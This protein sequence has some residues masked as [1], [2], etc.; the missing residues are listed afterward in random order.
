MIKFIFTKLIP[1]ALAIIMG[2]NMIAEELRF[3]INIGSDKNYFIQSA[4]GAFHVL[5]SESPKSR[6]IIA[7][8][9]GN[10][11]C[12]LLF[13]GTNAP[14]LIGEP[15]INKNESLT[16]N[17][18]SPA[19]HTISKTIL[20]SLR[21]TRNYTEGSGLKPIFK[22]IR[23]NINKLG[24]DTKAYNNAEKWLNP[25]W[26]ISENGKKAELYIT[27]LDCKNWYK[28]LIEAKTGNFKYKTQNKKCGFNS[29]IQIP[30]GIITITYASSYN[31][32]TPFTLDT[33]LNKKALKIINKLDKPYIKDQLNGLRFL[34]YHEK[35]LAGSWRFLTYFGRDPLLALRI[36]TPILSSQALEAGIKAA[37][38]R[39]NTKGEIAH[40]EDVGDQAFIDKLISENENL[41]QSVN[42]PDFMNSYNMVDEIFLL[43]PLLVDYYHIGGR[44][45]FSEKGEIRDGILRNINYV[46]Q[47]AYT[48]KPIPNKTGEAVGDWRDSN[49]GL[50]N[51][52]Y[53]FSVN[54]ALV[55][56]ALEALNT[57]RDK[58]VWDEKTLTTLASKNNLQ[59][60]NKTIKNPRK[61]NNVLNTW[62][63]MWIKFQVT[64]TSEL[65]K[66]RLNKHR[67]ESGFQQLTGKPPYN[68]GFLALS[69]NNQLKPIDIIQS[70]TLFMLLDFPI[71][72]ESKWLNPA[73][74]PFEINF[75]DGL[76]SGAGLLVANPALAPQK[77]YKMFDKNQYHGEVIW[78]WPQLMLKVALLKQLNKW[79]IPPPE[80]TK[81]HNET[82]V[83][84]TKILTNISSLIDSLREWSTSELWAWKLD[85][86]GKIIPIPYGQDAS[87]VT[88][89]NAVQ[90]WSVAALGLEV[91]DLMIKDS[92]H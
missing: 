2:T 66:E 51:G 75:P 25:Q 14:E 45:I 8:P 72:Q 41:Q 77:Y 36:M 43:L 90:L 83:K 54:A 6:C 12:M 63:K 81:L 60:I 27:A 71:D 64:E 4:K 39:I 92:K 56:A 24:K 80:K 48:Q 31:P 58:N 28:L 18:N 86:N 50:A 59:Y 84:L 9:A 22:D 78:A 21:L 74:S 32:L 62:R 33:L 29:S 40:E 87:N 89:S 61:Y 13:D 23:K 85:K 3:K 7:S 42:H 91:W 49:T 76:M 73:C 19:P 47:E 17:L 55:P 68:S 30:S 5:L 1:T 57:L 52:K 11:G 34:A 46:L 82:K 53:A 26:K 37:A 44:N 88:E 38:V 35:F 15:I 70:D 16:I 65:E 20:G 10:A 69:L 67:K 79:I